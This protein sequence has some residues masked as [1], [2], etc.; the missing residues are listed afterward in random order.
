MRPPLALLLG[1]VAGVLETCVCVYK[2]VGGWVVG[3][4][5]GWSDG[6]MVGRMEPAACLPTSALAG[7][8]AADGGSNRGL[9]GGWRHARKRCY[10]YLLRRL[11]RACKK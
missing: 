4:L 5:A 1:P 9:H 3:W 10:C 6:W 11:R 2:L 8:E 7:Q